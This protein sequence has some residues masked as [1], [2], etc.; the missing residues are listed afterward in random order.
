LTGSLQAITYVEGY[1]M[2]IGKIQKFI[3]AVDRRDG[4]IDA[5]LRLI[6]ELVDMDWVVTGERLSDGSS[7]GVIT[8]GEESFNDDLDALRKKEVPVPKFLQGLSEVLEGPEIY[9][10]TSWC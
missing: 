2:D 9:K 8:F 4:R 6:M 7:L 5:M 1:G 10:L 3:G